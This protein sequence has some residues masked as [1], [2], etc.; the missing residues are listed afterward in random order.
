[1]EK[2][3][4]CYGGDVSLLLDVCRARVLFEGAAD[5]EACLRAVI[6]DGSGAR[7]VRVK[8]RLPAPDHLFRVISPAPSLETPDLFLSLQP[9]PLSVPAP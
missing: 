7:V 3:T 4:V 1:M 9:M 2:A 5:L 6:A 8:S